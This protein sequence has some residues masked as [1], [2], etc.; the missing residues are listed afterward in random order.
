MES[1]KQMIIAF[2]GD[3]FS[4]DDEGYP[5][6]ISRYFN[7]IHEN[8]ST[9]ASS[10][11]HTYQ[12]LQHRFSKDKKA[13]NVAIITLTH[14]DRLFH[15]RYLIRGSGAVDKEFN[16][17]PQQFNDAVSTY[18]TELFSKEGSTLMHRMY[19]SALAQFS[20]DHP[21]TKFIF[22][23]CFDSFTG[24]VTGNYVVT[25]PRI[26]NFA[27][28]DLEIHMKEFNGAHLRNNHLND[29]FNKNLANII[30]REIENY[31]YNTVK[32]VDILGEMML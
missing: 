4:H 30:I 23:P 18:Y 31:K 21:L 27:E 7:G 5:G 16:L 15:D 28:I 32:H 6:Q 20:L 29:R 11:L 1:N 13:P 19:C 8:Y 22:L 2:F 17:A 25:G 3:S 24:S 12:Q 10:P 14:S 9:P 26:M